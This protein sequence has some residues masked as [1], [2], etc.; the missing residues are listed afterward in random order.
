MGVT[1]TKPA[2]VQNIKWTTPTVALGHIQ[3]TKILWVYFVSFNAGGST[4]WT[5]FDGTGTDTD[6]YNFI[7]Q[8][9]GGDLGKIYFGSHFSTTNGLWTTNSALSTGTLYQIAITY[10]GGATTNDPIIYINGASV[11]ITES[12]TPAG[13]YRTG[14]GTD[15]YI[16]TPITDRAP[17]AY[18]FADLTYNRI[19]SAT[20]ILDA[21]NSRLAIPTRRGLVFAPNL[22]GAAGLQ[23]FGGSTLTASNTIVDNISGAIGTP[24]G[25][26]VGVADTFL[27]YEG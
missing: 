19:L 17:D 10:D 26:P 15:Y 1:F 22:C 20:E 4:L 24:N 21:Y 23:T 7:V 11:A 18:I 14:I 8:A 5:I 9:A 2:A 13:T 6:E 3:K 16:S 12:L 25:S 27:T